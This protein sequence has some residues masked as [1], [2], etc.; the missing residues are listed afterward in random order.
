VGT[1]YRTATHLGL[2][3]D[4]AAAR[5]AVRTVLDL[6]RDIGRELVEHFQI[7]E[8]R[9]LAQ[10]KD[11]YLLRP[12][13][14]RR[15]DDP[16]REIIVRECPAGVDL[17]IVIGDGLSVAAVAAQAP[18]LMPRLIENAV[19]RGWRVGR[20]FVVHYC[21]VGILNEIGEI[22][23]P[24]VVVLLIGERPGLATAESLSAYLAYRPRPGDTDAKRNLISNIHRRGVSETEATRRILAL[25]D[26]MMQL[27][28]SGV[29]VK[30][31][32]P[33]LT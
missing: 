4:H 23:D 1:S 3:S 29:D 18:G 28:A 25:A 22:L 31:E 9:T 26:R 32:L 13:R 7:F 6:N 12:D 30:E 8:A 15:F 11:D 21:R 33:A 20:P 24:A 16:S 10:S 27:R 2:R 5:D 17:Q 14:G 19:Q